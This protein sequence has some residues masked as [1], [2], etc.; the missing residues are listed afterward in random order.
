MS[1]PSIATDVSGVDTAVDRNAPTSGPSPEVS[2]PHLTGF[3][4]TS[5][6]G[7]ARF[8]RAKTSSEAT[9]TSPETVELLFRHRS[10]GLAELLT[11]IR[12]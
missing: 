1:V 3:S 5:A 8:A 6:G 11:N 10:S 2:A 4:A 9:A 7:P 12:F